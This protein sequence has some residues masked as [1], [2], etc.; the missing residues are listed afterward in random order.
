MTAADDIGSVNLRWS[1]ALVHG[2]IAAG[3]RDLVLSPGSRSSALA[4]AFLRR[5]EVRCHVIL[6]E[7][8]AAFFALGIARADRRA[9][10]LL[11]TSGSAPGNWLPAVIEADLAGVPLLLLSAARPPEVTGWGAHQTLDQHRL[12]G[13]H[14]RAF[15]A[16]ALPVDDGPPAYLQHLAAR[17]VAECHWPSPGPVH[18][19][20]AFREPLLPANAAACRWVASPPA[21]SV[22][23]PQLLP[24]RTLVEACAALISGRQ[25][26]IV[27]GGADYPL[28][29]A[30]T[31]ADLAAELDCPILAEPLSG[32]RFGRADRSRLCVR[33]DTY[34]RAAGF[35]SALCPDW[36]LRFGAFPVVKSLQGWL[37]ATATTA[38]QL[39]VTA[40]T[41][42]PDPEH[43]A[44]WMIQADPSALC[45]ALCATGVQ[46]IAPAW[47]ARFAAAEA[48]AAKLA[49]QYHQRENFEGAL[50]PV[51]L[52]RLPPEHRL[53]CGNSL[54]IRDLDTF[55]GSAGKRLRIFANRGASG[56]DGNLS[57]ALGI[58]SSG[59]CV[60]L[61][62]DLTA[63]H[64]LTALAA[65][66]GRDI[67]VVVIN[68]G[69]GGI[70]EYLPVVALPEFERAWL[71]PQ[72]V[73][74]VAA[75]HS[76]GVT[77]QRTRS[78]AEFT[79]AFEQALQRGGA[80]LLEV[81]VDRKQSVAWHHDFQQ[82]ATNAAWPC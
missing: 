42:W 18:L 13:H 68:N 10:G 31:V 76:F 7:R 24:E 53:F 57:T 11:C 34:L 30:D 79:T 27:C 56:I 54:P 9:V 72:P 17:V 16:P 1:H 80:T 49:Q 4:L 67:V 38:Q 39:V 19:N 65:A 78:L 63:Q 82:V 61:V 12:F 51:L 55:S 8:S 70:F 3:L 6:D 48:L 5:T 36:I 29:F 2:L 66:A 73:D 40:D 46:A 81:I 71:T 75:A 21:V 25:G 26:V 50:I 32:L 60:A 64:D 33:Y 44:Q 14:V 45:A 23:H 20:L 69:G 58:A 15:H 77:A 62:G 74:L 43:A 52:A 35:R 47:R 37:A 59:P 28:D 22:A 41:R